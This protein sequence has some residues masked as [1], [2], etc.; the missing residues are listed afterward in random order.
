MKKAVDNLHIA[1]ELSSNNLVSATTSR[2]ILSEYFF[3]QQQYPEARVHLF[4]GFRKSRKIRA[5][6]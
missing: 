1:L 5:K 6:R 2:S 4:G 3:N